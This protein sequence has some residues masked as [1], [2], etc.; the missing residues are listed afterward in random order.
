MASD[1]AES[2]LV[3]VQENEVEEAPIQKAILWFEPKAVLKA[4]KSNVWDLISSKEQKSVDP[5]KTCL[6][7]LDEDGGPG[8]KVQA[9]EGSR[10]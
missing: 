7:S 3:V 4:V 9:H 10:G 1:D 6:F 5:R 8:P 2:D